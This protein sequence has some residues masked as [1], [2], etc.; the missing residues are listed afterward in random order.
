MSY[1]YNKQDVLDFA[2]MIQT[3][4]HEKGNELFFR[5]CPYCQGGSHKD[6]DT[7]SINLENGT[8][9]CF[10]SGCGKKGHFVELARDFGFQLDFGEAKPYK[11][12]PQRKIEIRPAAITYLES[13]GISRVV[14]EEYKVTTAKD[15]QNVLVFPFYDENGIMQFVKYRKTDFDR[16]KDKNKEWSEAGAKPI[17]FGMQQCQDKTALVITEGQI[18]S[19]SVAEAGIKNAVSVPNGAR[20]F[21]W[22]QHC[23]DWLNEFEEIIVF[24][25]NEHGQIT[26]VNELQARVSQ[27]VRVVRVVDYLG[28]K[29]ANDI[30]RKYG[31]E[32]IIKAIEN[33]EVPKLKNV[34][35]LSEVKSVNL[36]DM[37]KVRTGL[38]ELDKVIGGLY[39]GQVSLW[40]GKRG[41]GKSTLA[42]QVI[43]EAVDQNWNVFVYSGELP[44]YHFKR[45][46]DMQLAGPDHL[47]KNED[48]FG[49]TYYTIPDDVQKKINDWY[50]DKIY[51]YDNAYIPETASETE[52]LLTTVEK[53]IKQYD[54]KLIC[55]DNLMTAMEQVDGKD[56]LYTAQSN[57]VWS[58]KNLAMRYNVHI[59]LV[60]H[61]RKTQIGE[62]SNDDISGSG[63]IT[64]KVDTVIFYGRKSSAE[65]GEGHIT[66]T[67]NRLTGK[68]AV[69]KNIIET[70]YSRSSKRIATGEKDAER[71]YGWEKMQQSKCDEGF[72]VISN[73][74][75]CPF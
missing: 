56:N 16:A 67:K 58:L 26:L 23:A 3:E 28:E 41:E 19:L 25:D 5:E 6:K 74:A 21:T 20:G 17:L 37:P 35:K 38:H 72:Y 66:V 48:I 8:F 30:L 24:G 27:K 55:L 52:T 34:K 59:M 54:T 75:E 2:S 70:Q 10:R 18:D 53:V 60:A 65:D 9:Y 45:W 22:Y 11:Q 44:D 1:E 57:F 40:S 46:L 13:R 29:D 73:D 51:I 68:L 36:M 7:F 43:A 39:M 63:D 33:A 32:A 42:S 71:T 61:P 50:Q 15:N 62:M 49:D 47:T 31:K 69:G 12:L 64:N 14:A 4:K